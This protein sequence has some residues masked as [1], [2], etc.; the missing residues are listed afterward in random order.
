MRSA[1]LRNYLKYLHNCGHVVLITE[2]KVTLHKNYKFESVAFYNYTDIQ[3][4]CTDAKSHNS[5]RIIR[6]ITKKRIMAHN[7]GKF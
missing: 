6:I 1:N 7:V 4:L 2:R 5:A 3:E